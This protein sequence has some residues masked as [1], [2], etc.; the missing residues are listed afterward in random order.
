MP[1]AD[2]RDTWNCDFPFVFN[3]SGHLNT[4]LGGVPQRIGTGPAVR[5]V[6]LE[7]ILEQFALLLGMT[8][9]NRRRSASF[10]QESGKYIRYTT[11]KLA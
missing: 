6:F 7:R 9:S 3:G 5:Q 11:G 2:V 4:Y 8:R 1:A 10:A